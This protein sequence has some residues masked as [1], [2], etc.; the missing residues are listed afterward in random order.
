[1]RNSIVVVYS[2]HL[3]LEENDKFNNHIKKKVINIKENNN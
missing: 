2:P 3:T 1:M